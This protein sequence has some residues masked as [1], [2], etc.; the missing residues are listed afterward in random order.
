MY[1]WNTADAALRAKS[2]LYFTY[3]DKDFLLP[4]IR[5]AVST[6]KTK[7]FAVTEN[8]VAGATHCAFDGNAEVMRIWSANP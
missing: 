4:D 1:S 8:V 7:G 6:F 2:P 5:Q 3:G